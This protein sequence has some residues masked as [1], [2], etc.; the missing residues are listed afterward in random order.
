VPWQSGSH[1]PTTRSTHSLAFTR[2]RS[3]KLT[4]FAQVAAL[5]DEVDGLLALAGA[6]EVSHGDPTAKASAHP[7]AETAAFSTDCKVRNPA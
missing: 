6:R 5:Q 7:A 4:R 1:N 2:K 3:Q